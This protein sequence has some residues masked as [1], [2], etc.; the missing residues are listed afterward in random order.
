MC[1]MTLN[2][3]HLYPDLMNTYG[4]KGNV[5]ALER[6]CQWRDISCQVTNLSRQDILEPDK[7]DIIFLGAGQDTESIYEDMMQVKAEGLRTA[8]NEGNVILGISSGYQMLGEYYPD[9]KGNSLAGLS[10]LDM[11]TEAGTDRIPGNVVCDCIPLQG[12]EPTDS[13][14]VGFESHSGKT[15]LGNGVSPLAKVIQGQGNN[16]QDGTEGVCYGNIFGSYL[17]GS[18][19][20]K[21]YRLTDLL[22]LR[23]LQRKYGND[24]AQA[25]IAVLPDSTAEEIARLS[26]INRILHKESR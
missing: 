4:D 23:A 6:R 12:A 7:Y 3:C 10:I 9:V 20:P 1:A 14:I 26:C 15:F 18:L 13:Y 16:G 19:L 22:I 11:R 17:H 21:N 8:A 25:A 24:A 2:I 5:I